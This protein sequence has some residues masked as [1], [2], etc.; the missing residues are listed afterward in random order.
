MT[1]EDFGYHEGQQVFVSDAYSEF[2][3]VIIGITNTGLI[4]VRD[5]DSGDILAGSDDFIETI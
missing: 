2:D 4:R 3:G 5:L 1:L